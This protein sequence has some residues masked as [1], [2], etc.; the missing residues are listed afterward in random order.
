M[1]DQ[2][3]PPVG[4][5]AVPRAPAAG[6]YDRLW[7]T[8]LLN[9][10]S[11]ARR[12][13]G[14]FFVSPI[15]YVVGALIIIPV[16]LFGYLTQLAGQAPVTMSGVYSWTTYLSVLLIPL[17]TM[18][19]LAEER[20]TG[21]LELLLTS[22]VRDWELAAGKWLGA[23]V[24]FLAVTAF[25]VVFAVLLFAYEPL[26]SDLR[27]L[28]LTVNVANLDYGTMLSGYLGLALVGA[29]YVAVGLLVSS[30]TSNQIIAAFAGVIALIGLH[31]GLG[32]LASVVKD[33]FKTIF[34]YAGGYNRYLS[35]SQGQL[36]LKDVVYFLTLLLGALFLTTRVVESRKWR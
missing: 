21:S 28:G 31:W 5:E 9:V 2:T 12:E 15:A 24:F 16:A 33:P 14:S 25:V 35:F 20:R 7:R 34:D 27:L 23:V 26:R 8:G 22:P 29:T 4:A 3:D 19:L 36:V 32:D 18:R 11:I 1:A 6:A 30:L 17:F 13:L 10:G